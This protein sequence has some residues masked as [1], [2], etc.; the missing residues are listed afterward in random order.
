MA[1]RWTFVVVGALAAAACAGPD[2]PP[3]EASDAAQAFARA[4]SAGKASTAVDS[5]TSKVAKATLAEVTTELVIRRTT[6]RTRGELTCLDGDQADQLNDGRRVCR[7][8]I[9]VSHDLA[10]LGTWRY[11]ST[12]EVREDSEGRWKVWWAPATFHPQL[13]DATKLDRTRELP[14]RAPILD[15][16][17]EP[18]TQELPVVRV[19]VEPGK[20]RPEVTYSR[21]AS[22]LGID[23]GKLRSRA[24]AAPPT[25][26]VDV[27]TLRE[28]AYG[29][30]RSAVEGIP[31][32]V[33]HKDTMSLAPT[34][35]FARAVLG[36]V[37]PATAESLKDAG[38]LA[39]ESDEIGTSGLQKAYQSQLAGTP[40]GSIDVVDRKSGTKVREVFRLAARPGKPLKTTL[41]TSL[42][43][44][45]E[46]AI[47]SQEKPTAL[48]AVRASTGE[49]L[50]TANGPGVTSYNR[51][52]VGKYPPGSTF[53]VVS[54]AA[55]LEGGLQVDDRVSCPA[56]TNIGGKRFKNAY[57][58]SL[59]DGPLLTAFA[60]SCNTALVQRAETLEGSALAAMA[61]R[62]GIGETWKLGLPAY[63]GSVPEPQDLV[64]RAA[65]MIGQGRVLLS[66]LGMAMVAATVDSGQPR[67]PVLLP[68][69]A[70]GQKAGE[71]LPAD[72]GDDLRTL[73]RAVVETGS[74]KALDLP[75]A[76]PVFAKTGTAEYGS[77]DPPRTH[78]WMIG[79][80]GDIAFAVVIEDGGGGGRDAGPVAL[81]FLQESRFVQ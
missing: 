33:T 6:V 52:F 77:E 60:R 32:V 41:D 7:Q 45:A 14:E 68:D 17:G 58:T 22:V 64:D 59:P 51:A 9:A 25:Q 72:L 15:Q 55:L 31:G 13:T 62:F 29:E 19:G 43:E 56:E 67:T 54:V 8:G 61:D 50:A 44:A 12:A 78:A 70:P 30:I 3:K 35:T 63:S 48:V 16:Q 24:E 65:S 10:G 49:I 38:P 81:R 74:A 20:V 26:F 2:G 4:W 66:P 69:V 34:S 5:R 28:G 40:G 71:V 73:M 46:N 42:Q 53:K 23:P 57:N 27:I 37:G 11:A 1:V 36:V 18:L 80:R 21:L 76:Q 47:E 79:F 39:M 75:G